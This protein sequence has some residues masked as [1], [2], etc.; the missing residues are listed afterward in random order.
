MYTPWKIQI[1]AERK[2]FNVMSIQSGDDTV[3]TIHGNDEVSAKRARLIAAAPDLLEAAKAIVE[4][5][6]AAREYPH[7]ADVAAEIK[8]FNA[9][10]A[11]IDKATK[12]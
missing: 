1:N 8:A 5:R 11:A 3:A 2:L 7:D 12:P 6:S 10:H 9:I 4:L